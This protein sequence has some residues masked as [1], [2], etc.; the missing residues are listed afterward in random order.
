MSTVPRPG[1][2]FPFSLPRDPDHSFGRYSPAL[3]ST[4]TASCYLKA[5]S[6]EAGLSLVERLRVKI[7]DRKTSA[8]ATR[9]MERIT[10]ASS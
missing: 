7:W 3:S 5:D 4:Q 6:A 8:A 2:S 9:R 1:G 10:P